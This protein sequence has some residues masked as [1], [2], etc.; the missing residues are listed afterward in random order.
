[1]AVQA[2]EAIGLRAGDEVITT[3]MTFAATAEVVRYFDARPALTLNVKR[4]RTPGC[5]KNKRRSG[6]G[7]ARC[8]PKTRNS[9]GC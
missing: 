3:P 5:A 9:P 2:L 4:K 8:R 6:D 7:C 1:M